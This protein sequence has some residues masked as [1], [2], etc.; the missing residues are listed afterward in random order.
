MCFKSRKVNN[1]LLQQTTFFVHVHK[2]NHPSI[3][4]FIR[5]ADA[6]IVFNLLYIENRCQM[7]T[8]CACEVYGTSSN[9]PFASFSKKIPSIHLAVYTISNFLEFGK[10]RVGA[11]KA[12]KTLKNALSQAENFEFS[13]RRSFWENSIFEKFGKHTSRSF[14]N[15]KNKSCQC[16]TNQS[17][18]M[19][20]AP[21]GSNDI[22]F[23]FVIGINESLNSGIQLPIFFA[24]FFFVT[25]HSLSLGVASSFTLLCHSGFR[26]ELMR[27]PR[28]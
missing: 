5:C 9:L 17:V 13:N 18:E 6:T 16:N 22:F 20:D 4:K 25:C 15:L 11:G 2:T 12:T 21:W 28:S 7:T 23:V 1:I 26:G 8:A 27:W 14:N 24:R 19:T 10:K 3:T